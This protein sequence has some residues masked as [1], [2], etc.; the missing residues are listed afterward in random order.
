MSVNFSLRT[1]DGVQKEFTSLKALGDFLSRRLPEVKD[2]RNGYYFTRG[3][4]EGRRLKRN[5]KPPY[6]VVLDVD[7]SQI[8]PEEC[9]KRLEMFDV[10]HFFY[11]THSHREPEAI[12]HRYRV[13]TDHLADSWDVVQNTVEQ[14]L[15]LIGMKDGADKASWKSQGFGFVFLFDLIFQDAQWYLLH[16]PI[17]VFLQVLIQDLTLE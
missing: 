11:T 10:D 16:L 9:S 5:V 13:I 17:Q 8:E 3:R 6:L 15:E 2:K 4:C 14:M 7:E 1:L 12:G